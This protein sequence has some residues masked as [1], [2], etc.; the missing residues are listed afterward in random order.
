MDHDEFQEML[1]SGLPRIE[2]T[3]IVHKHG[4]AFESHS[5]VALIEGP[6]GP[7][8]LSLFLYRPG[9][10]DWETS[11]SAMK[12]ASRIVWNFF[13]FQKPY[14]EGEA[15]PMPELTPPSGY[16]PLGQFVPAE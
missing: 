8:V 7:Y 1:W 2:E 6:T 11:N 5:D 12:D 3:W 14:L 15:P 16:V 13:E 10:M 9:W 4:F